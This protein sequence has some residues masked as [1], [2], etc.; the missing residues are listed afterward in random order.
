MTVYE[1]GPQNKIQYVIVW[2]TDLLHRHPW[3]EYWELE[4]NRKN[5]SWTRTKTI[6]EWKYYIAAIFNLGARGLF[7]SSLLCRSTKLWGEKEGGRWGRR[8][9]K[10]ELLFQSRID[11]HIQKICFDGAEVRASGWGSGGP[12]L[13]FFKSLWFLL[14]W[15]ISNYFRSFSQYI[16]AIILF[17]MLSEFVRNMN[18]LKCWVCNTR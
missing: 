8:K 1:P 17:V 14:S 5:F 11:I 6:L 12:R 9:K 4:V 2:S 13:L 16:A 15:T 10:E 7:L 3:I 18:F